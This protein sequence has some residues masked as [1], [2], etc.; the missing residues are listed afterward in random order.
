[1][2]SKHLSKGMVFSWILLILSFSYQDGETSSELS[3]TFVD[4]L[5]GVIEVFE[6]NFQDRFD[7][8]SIHG[9]IRGLAHFSLYFVLGIFSAHMFHQHFKDWFR[10]GVDATL[11]ALVI[12]IF[13]EMFQSFIPGRAMTLNDVFIDAL[14]ALIGAALYVFLTFK[15][16][17]DNLII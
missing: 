15:I 3:T 16:F 12:A 17:K 1:M 6:P 13:D 5:I 11:F 4:T 9:L 7:I 14:G 8:A 10:I 2:M